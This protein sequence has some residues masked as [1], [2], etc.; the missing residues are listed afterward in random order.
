ME[1]P[2]QPTVPP[3]IYPEI[4]GPPEWLESPPTLPY[5]CLLRS[6]CLALGLLAAQSEDQAEPMSPES[7]QQMEVLTPLLPFLFRAVGD[8]PTDPQSLQTL[9]YWPLS[10]ANLYN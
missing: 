10:S 5:L 1:P 2:L 9:Q 4:K 8:L 6:L 7:P 3:K